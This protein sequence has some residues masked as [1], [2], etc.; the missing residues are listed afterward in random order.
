MNCK[1]NSNFI[2]GKCV[3]NDGFSYNSE[4]DKCIKIIKELEQCKVNIVLCKKCKNGITCKTCK[5]NSYL[6]KNK[7]E[8]LL[9][10]KYNFKK[11]KCS[12]NFIF[13]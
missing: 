3:C 9:G 12:G 6:K 7:C 10:Y 13:K 5:K 8:C 11:D 1:K 2:T 4:K